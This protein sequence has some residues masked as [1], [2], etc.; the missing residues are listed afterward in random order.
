MF[1]KKKRLKPPIDF[2]KENW[3]PILK[4]SICNGEKV[5]GFKHKQTGQFCEVML[6]RDAGELDSFLKMYELDNITKEY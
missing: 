6:I 4:C 3:H 2:D 5:A 1:K